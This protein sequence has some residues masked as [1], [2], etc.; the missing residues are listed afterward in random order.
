MFVGTLIAAM[1][2]VTATDKLGP[3]LGFAFEPSG[4]G[5][6]RLAT[7][8]SY[9][10]G[11]VDDV[12]RPGFNGR[13][14][15]GETFIG[16]VQGAYPLGWGSPGPTAYG[17]SDRDFSQVHARVGHQVVTISPW[18]SI[19]SEGLQH[20]EAARVE[21]LKREGYVGGVRTFVNDLYL[22]AE[23]RLAQREPRATIELPIDMPSFRSRQQ[24]MKFQPGDRVSLPPVASVA[25]AARVAR[26]MD[27]DRGSRLASR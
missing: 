11:R 14:W 17:A 15:L 22:M 1:S 4:V 27:A 18:I 7:M 10:A 2:V 16:G 21:W 8:P 3:Y 20:L 23:P 13:L 6:S 24:V 19:P 5:V 12:R 9:P 25:M 26:L